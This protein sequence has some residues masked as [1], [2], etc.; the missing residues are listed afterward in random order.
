MR[1]WTQRNSVEHKRRDFPPRGFTSILDDDDLN[2]G[3][4]DDH[5]NDDDDDLDNDDDDDLNN[6]DDDDGV[7]INSAWHKLTF[8]PC[9]F[10]R[11]PMLML[12]PV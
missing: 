7:E 11:P 9:H 10:S 8:V 4:D 12:F 1:C 3:D 2:N 5:G 6:G